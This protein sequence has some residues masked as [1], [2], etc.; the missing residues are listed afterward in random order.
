MQSKL[1]VCSEL[2]NI[3]TQKSRVKKRL[4]NEIRQKAHRTSYRAKKLKE[5][6]PIAVHWRT[7]HSQAVPQVPQ[8]SS[9]N[10]DTINRGLPMSLR[11]LLSI[12]WFSRIKSKSKVKI[13]E[14]LFLF[15]LL[16]PRKMIQIIQSEEKTK[17]LKTLKNIPIQSTVSLPFRSIFTLF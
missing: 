8:L 12:K 14:N 17:D 7:Y 5:K 6:N 2:L 4:C 16:F 3:F 13:L 11:D 15:F 1:T 10:Q 9:C